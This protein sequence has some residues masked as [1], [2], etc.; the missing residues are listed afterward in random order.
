MN[1]WL[2]VLNVGRHQILAD[3]EERTV[4]VEEARADY[5]MRS[6]PARARRLQR[7]QTISRAHSANI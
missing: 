2:T 4:T 1:D 5:F 7:M 6:V 3:H